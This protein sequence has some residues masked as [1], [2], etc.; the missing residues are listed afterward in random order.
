M[1]IYTIDTRQSTNMV[2]NTYT[3]TYMQ[4]THTT[5]SEQ[6]QAMQIACTPKAYY[7]HTQIFHE[8]TKIQKLANVCVCVCIQA[9]IHGEIKGDSF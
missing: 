5:H 9:Y 2:T 8:Y 7:K 1:Y 3:H 4:Y 6:K